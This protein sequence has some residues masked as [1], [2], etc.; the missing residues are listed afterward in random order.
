M[1][2]YNRWRQFFEKHQR[3][4]FFLSLLFS[5]LGCTLLETDG[6]GKKEVRVGDSFGG[7]EMVFLCLVRFVKWV[8][9]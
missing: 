3:V 6:D 8:E 5:L 7:N 1:P 4:P 2:F 9:C